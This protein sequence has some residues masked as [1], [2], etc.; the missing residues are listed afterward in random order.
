MPL[1]K[2]QSVLRDERTNVLFFCQLSITMLP[3]A[4]SE[5]P[6]VFAVQQGQPGVGQE[7]LRGY[8]G[9]TSDKESTCQYRRC[10]QI[11]GLERFPGGGNGNPLQYSWLGNPMDREAQQATQSDMTEYAH[12][13]ILPQ[14]AQTS[15]TSQQDIHVH[16][17]SY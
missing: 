2:G 4:H 17:Q 8:P 7:L 10:G 9:G 14:E 3:E 5:L 11:P 15:C 12:T 16:Q 13:H 1:L 6:P